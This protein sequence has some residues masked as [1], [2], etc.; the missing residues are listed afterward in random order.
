M[1]RQNRISQLTLELY[2]R[3]LATYKERKQ[4]EKALK[5]DG[6][7]QSR[8]KSI[9]ESDRE[10]QQILLQE[11]RRLNIQEIPPSSI[12]KRKKIVWGIIAAAAIL[13][14]AFIPTFLYLKHSGSNK[15]TAIVK[16]SN[17][18]IETANDL[19][20]PDNSEIEGLVDIS[21]D[22]DEYYRDGRVKTNEKTNPDNVKKTE[23]QQKGTAKETIVENKTE[24]SGGSVTIAA[25]PEADTGIRTRGTNSEQ[26]SVVI[27]PSEQQS[28]LNIPPGL[29]FIFE[30]MFANK[31]L[32][33]V[34]IPDRITSIGK[35]AFSGNPLVNVIIGANVAVDDEAIPGNFAKAYNN[36]D[37]AAGI[38]T[39]PDS[40]SEA[41]VKK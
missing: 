35:N 26:Q 1:K 32:T 12:S 27:T 15:N 38:Y 21:Y 22:E 18:E 3:G 23:T 41:W 39:R 8:Y 5:T 28:N 37:K 20:I 14:C 7:L 33:A 40:N 2:Y 36:N 17:T 4:V 13:I 31:Q 25:I 9:Q 30:N 6:K 10:I 11:L 24:I 16:G 29:T 19:L 34:I